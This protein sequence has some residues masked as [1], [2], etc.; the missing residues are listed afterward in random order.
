MTDL[1]A[2]IYGRQS[3]GK[4]K[5][6]DEQVAA[7]TVVAAENG[8]RVSGVYKDGSSASRYA[9]KGRDDWQRVLGDIAAGALDVLVLWEASRGDRTL[10]SWSQM[11]DLC[12]EQGVTIYIISDERLYDPARAKDWE[13]LA[14]SGVSSASESDKISIRVKRGQAGAAAAGRPSHGRAPYGYRRTYDPATG[15][16][17]GQE[18]DPDKA[19]IVREVFARLAKGDTVSAITRDFRERKIPTSTGSGRWFPIRVLVMARNKAY[20]GERVYRGT[21]T[22][23]A[24]P[25]L[26]DAEQFYAV[27]RILG[28]PKRGTMKPGKTRHLLSYIGTC[29]PC[30]WPLGAVQGRYRCTRA[31]CV[32]FDQATA[33]GV[34]VEMI[35]GRLSQPDV[36]GQLRQKSDD[37]NQA[38]V[39]LRNEVATLQARLEEWRVSAAAGETSP[40][41]MA[42]IEVKL[43]E[44]IQ[45]AQRRIAL[46]DVPPELQ[47]VLVPGEDVRVRWEAAPLAAR[48]RIVIA[49]AEVRVDK[50]VVDGSM[51]PS[52]L[53]LGGS[54]WNGDTATWADKWA[55]TE[56]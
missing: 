18:P 55:H 6:I 20:V 11:L 52:H 3:R 13:T 22:P 2:G 53:R 56:R 17:T 10:T 21:A 44:Q 49:L 43:A 19:S 50:A 24:W 29:G 34:V 1:R 39:D 7:G 40:A 16:L 8:W 46:T 32:T 23:G 26:V 47:A 48:R 31:G 38:V 36:Y 9:R 51:L 30:G 12:R 14:T 45:S 33:D 54:R 28:D 37:A 4:A 5:S 15:E 35:L 42:A 41:T 27:Q 25:A